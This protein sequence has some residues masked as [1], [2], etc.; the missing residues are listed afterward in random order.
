MTTSVSASENANVAQHLALRARAAPEGLAAAAPGGN[1]F[2]T[3][4]WRELD[5]KSSNVAWGLKRLGLAPADRVCVFV[6]PGL[7]WLALVHGL[8]KLG[9]V[10]VLIDPGMGR[11]G[12]LAATLR[13]Q[14]RGLIAVAALHV[15]RRLQPGAFRS[16]EIALTDRSSVLWGKTS[17]DELLA[18]ESPDFPP[19]ERSPRDEAAILFTSG[20]TGPA[21]GVVYEHGMFQA[22]VKMLR[23]LYA[24]APGSA[25]LACFP[26]FALFGAALGL[27]SVF[28]EL[29]FSR[30]A[31]CDP[32]RIVAAIDRFQI[33]SSF[34]S[35]AIWRRVI[36]WCEV[37]GRR[38]DSLRQLMIAGAP[39]EAELVR[40]ARAVLGSGGEVFTPYG[41]TEALPV[42]HVEGELL[43]ATLGERAARGEGT[44]VGE[45]APSLEIR[46]IQ[47]SDE[48]IATWSADLEVPRGEAGE[49]CVRGDNVTREYKFEP[50]A[51]AAAKIADGVS[52]WHRMGDI[53][54]FDRGGK[55]WFLGRKSHRIESEHGTMYPVPFENVFELDPRV[56]RCALVGAGTRGREV[57]VLI[58]E[59]SSGRIPRDPKA[60]NEL[61]RELLRAQIALEPCTSID[62]VLFKHDF[63][64]DVRHQ[65]KI[66]RGALKTWAERRLR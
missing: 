66:D 29:D 23:E 25:D 19:I 14:P 58:V 55:L 10:V 13:I 46:L 30:P 50:G 39:V 18:S 62:R 47:V 22:Q 60:R 2:E 9:A 65:A 33:R 5:A 21:K 38:L 32:A 28:P 12:V 43:A 7:A 27:S 64:L 26:L 34:G 42:A 48:P 24:F 49:I 11:R 59:T 31:R 35:P 63:P 57:P 56:G 8:F 6:R 17:L 16:V 15:V 45:A 52:F 41:A 1:G 61:E 3:W 37:Q 36:P 54:R 44:C 40:R 20:S 53:G 4:T 51:T